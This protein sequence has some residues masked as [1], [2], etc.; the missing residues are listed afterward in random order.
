MKKQAVELLLV[1][2]CFAL[3]AGGCAKKEPVK[4]DPPLAPGADVETE[5]T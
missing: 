4:I 3:F 5:N 2:T 1:F